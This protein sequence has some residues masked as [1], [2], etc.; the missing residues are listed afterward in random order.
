MYNTL[1]LKHTLVI[2]INVLASRFKT[3]YI[4]SLWIHIFDRLSTHLRSMCM[5]SLA[6]QYHNN[7]I[8][9]AKLSTTTGDKIIF[10]DIN[11]CTPIISHSKLPCLMSISNLPRGISYRNLRPPT[12]PTI[13]NLNSKT[14]PIISNP[15]SNTQVPETS[16]S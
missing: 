16:R 13:H 6:P 7:L 12:V 8:I 9:P 11:L 1:M 10:C 4:T 5:T 15:G 2:R 14:P 3:S